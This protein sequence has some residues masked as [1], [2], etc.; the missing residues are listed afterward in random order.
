MRLHKKVSET[1]V[2]GDVISA[3]AGINRK[4][5]TIN[6]DRS[7][8]AGWRSFCF[9]APGV[10]KITVNDTLPMRSTKLYSRIDY[11]VRPECYWAPARNPLEAILRNVKGRNHREMI[12][13]YH[14]AGSAHERRDQH[15]AGI[16]AQSQ[17]SVPFEWGYLLS[18]MDI[19]DYRWCADR[20]GRRSPAIQPE[21]GL[22][23]PT[24]QLH[25][26][27]HRLGSQ[28][29]LSI[30]IISGRTQDDL[31]TWLGAYPF[32]LIAEHGASV[33]RPNPRGFSSISR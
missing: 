22:A 14:E 26:L 2:L 18:T 7:R 15:G 12:R 32:G 3:S 16:G 23:E 17:I 27:L 30:T 11:D 8:D 31:V 1:R 4:V 13:D 24:P 21:P 6:K 20:I 28:P 29:N 25:A 19:H 5:S 9:R 33:R 10:E